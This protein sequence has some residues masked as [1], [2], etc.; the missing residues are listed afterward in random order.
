MEYVDTD[1]D[2][3]TFRFFKTTLPAG[4]TGSEFCY[5]LVED[6]LS[7]ATPTHGLC[8]TRRMTSISRLMFFRDFR[9]TPADKVPDNTSL[10]Y[11]RDGMFDYE[12]TSPDFKAPAK[13]D[14][15]IYE[16]LFRD[17]TG[18]E[19]QAPGKRHRPRRHR[20]R[21]LYLKEPGIN[22]VELPDQ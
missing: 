3:N 17:F 22:A 1:I 5:Y 14:L 15:V 2:G 20:K 4:V 13:T 19:G 18:T 21:S 7:V 12:W 8:S 9:N 6:V 16:I 11:H 10:A